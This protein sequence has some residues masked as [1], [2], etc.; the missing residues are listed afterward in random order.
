VRC[1][2]WTRNTLRNCARGKSYSKIEKRGREFLTSDKRFAVMRGVLE[3]PAVLERALP[4]KSAPAHSRK[5][6]RICTPEELMGA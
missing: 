6:V 1:W 4:C 5:Q 3:R 2:G